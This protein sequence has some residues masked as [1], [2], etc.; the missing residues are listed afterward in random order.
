MPP[1]AGLTDQVTSELAAP[2]AVALNCWVCEL[3]R[4]TVAGDTVTVGLCPTATPWKRSAT[5]NKLAGRPSCAVR[6][7]ATNGLRGELAS[8]SVQFILF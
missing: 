3:V 1:N 4:D 5:S 7:V 6:A 8:K 2:V